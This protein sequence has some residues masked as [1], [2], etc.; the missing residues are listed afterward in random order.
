MNNNGIN[1]EPDYSSRDLTY[2]AQVA[3]ESLGFLTG[4]EIVL[5]NGAYQA[6]YSAWGTEQIPDDTVYLC[7]DQQ[8]GFISGVLSLNR[9]ILIKP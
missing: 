5:V 7:P 6:Y 9:A 3:Y 4:I 1:W 2:D 8:G